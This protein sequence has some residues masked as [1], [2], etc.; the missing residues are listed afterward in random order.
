MSHV[1][2]DLR[3]A[4]RQMRRSPGF[5]A[6]AVLALALGIGANSA[7]FTVV[8]AVLVRPLPFPEADRL[9]AVYEDVSH[10]GFAKNTPAPANW[11]DWRQQNTVFTEIAATRGRSKTLTGGG[12]PEQLRGRGVTASL[13]PLLGVQPLLGRVFTEEE[14]RKGERVVVISHGLWQR[15][16]GGEPSVVGTDIWL[17]DEKYRVI[18]VMPQGFF[19]PSRQMDIWVPISFSKQDLAR[20]GSHFLSCY[21]RLKP[22]V[23]LAQAQAD[24]SLIAKRLEQAYPESNTKI[25]AVVEPLRDQMVGKTKTALWVLL[26]AAGCVLLIACANI[27]N[28][29]LARAAGR[30]REFAVRAALGAGRWRI[31]AQSM[32]ESLLLAAMG[33][34][35][36]LAVARLSMVVLQK[37]IPDSLPVRQ[38]TVDPQVLLFTLA[39]TALT[40][41]LFGA[42]PGLAVARTDLHDTL[43]QGGRGGAGVRSP[44]FRNALVVSEV[45]LAALLLVGAGLLL[46]TLANLEARDP[47][48]RSDHLLT[49]NTS[50]PFPRYADAAKRE[51]FFLRVLDA[52]RT[53]PGVESVAYTSNLP[54]STIG[55]T[56]GYLIVGRPAPPNGNA[57]DALLRTVSDEF[58]QTMGAR[59]K[60]GRFFSSSDGLET[61]PVIIINETMAK[62]HWPGESP[63]GQKVHCPVDDK[64]P[65]RTVVGV[66]KDVNERGVELKMKPAVYVPLKQARDV[67]SVP[68]DLVVRTSVDP[69]SLA[70]P[71][72]QAIA[73]VDADQPVRLV[74]TM[75][76]VADE[77]VGA[78]RQQITILGSFAGLALLLA[79]VGIYGVLAY[80]V[81]L[82][83][84]EIGIRM[85]LGATNGDVIGNVLRH[86]LGMT[87]AGLAL[88][89][90]A[91]FGLTRAMASLL[92][93]VEPGDPST[94]AVAVGVLLA[95]AGLACWLPARSAGSVDPAVTLR[96]D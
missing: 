75:E 51:Q 49:I 30:Q 34:V 26:A 92:N 12:T 57:Q 16:F 91:A 58:L 73:A 55:N 21:A 47:G 78:R 15:R 42:A 29:L 96:E 88:G 85:A 6:I 77:Q 7:I 37:L 3:L 45:A 63:I 72:R 40:G 95:V 28:L 70:E 5:T 33:A 67:W 43:K 64:L 80:A 22:G 86:G 81:S 17:S 53:I 48:F 2:T 62:A 66:V 69:L 56:S 94:Y 9:M 39:L 23:T 41:I 44:L 52:A 14:D 1:L 20:R 4:L 93:G 54:Y 60:E 35:T 38:L 36:G 83:K 84:R 71:V 87:V 79:A 19:F 46:R 76:A 25:G 61:E 89:G 13:W 59:L 8:D 32:T 18:G 82:R 68:E 65:L 31:L 11:V 74:R 24:M 10:M 27:A 90:V 50:L